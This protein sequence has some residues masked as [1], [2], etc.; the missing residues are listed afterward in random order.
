MKRRPLL[1]IMFAILL[2]SSCGGGNNPTSSDKPIYPEIKVNDMTLNHY[3]EL[4]GYVVE[5]YFGNS[6]SITIPDYVTVEGKNIPIV[7]ISSYGLQARQGKA[8]LKEVEL[9]KNIYS[10]GKFA[11]QGTELT[12]LYATPYLSKIDKDAFT[13]CPYQG[14]EENGLYFIPSKTAQ[15]CVMYKGEYNGWNYTFPTDCYS[16]LVPALVGLNFGEV[17]DLSN[18]VSVG[19]GVFENI[20]AESVLFGPNLNRIESKAFINSSISQVLFGSDQP[21]KC[22]YVGDEA[23]ANVQGLQYI[24]LPASIQELGNNVFRFS[25]DMKYISLPFVGKNENTPT[26]AKDFFSI[27]GPYTIEHLVIDRGEI[28]DSSF[29]SVWGDYTRTIDNLTLNHVTKVGDQAFRDALIGETLELGDSLVHA[30]NNA[31]DNLTASTVSIPSTIKYLGSS[32]FY[33]NS[34]NHVFNVGRNQGDSGW[35]YIDP[36]W[37]NKNN[38]VINWGKGGGTSQ[39]EQSIDGLEYYTNESG[40]IVTGYKGNATSLTVPAEINGVAF[41]GINKGAFDQNGSSIK[42]LSIPCGN[43]QEHALAGCSSLQELEITTNSYNRYIS[44]CWSWFESSAK[45][46]YY[47]NSGT[48]HI[49]NGFPIT[50]EGYI[51]S[52]LESIK[53]NVKEYLDNGSTSSYVSIGTACFSGMTS[54]KKLEINGKVEFGENAF[55][56]CTSL[57][58]EI[59]LHHGSHAGYNAIPTCSL[60]F[61][62]E[63]SADYASFTSGDYYRIPPQLIASSNV[64]ATKYKDNSGLCYRD[65]LR[66]DGVV[67]VGYE[68]NASSLTVP[69]TLNGKTVNRVAAYSFENSSIE[70]LDLTN[71]AKEMGIEVYA[72]SN[73]YKLKELKL[74]HYPSVYRHTGEEYIIKDDYSQKLGVLHVALNCQDQSS[75]K[76]YKVVDYNFYIPKSLKYVRIANG[77][78]PMEGFR[79]YVSL[80][81]VFLASDCSNIK[82]KAFQG[83]TGLLDMWIPSSVTNFGDYCFPDSYKFIVYKEATDKNLGYGNNTVKENMKT[84]YSYSQYCQEVGIQE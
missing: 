79:S 5:D 29:Q 53:L 21:S 42:K 67:I 10:I 18:L 13:D 69:A 46:G 41:S 82:A 47:K 54:L 74:H 32:S 12:T 61:Y 55:E 72:L 39:D 75:S 30:G 26:N 50:I 7:A 43:I 14:Y 83:C 27:S 63:N 36:S 4:G 40:Y 20:Q 80:E 31:F 17:L 8:K 66:V 58:G 15:H 19:E 73:M 68:G 76:S 33:A 71:I 81:R 6:T 3:D 34:G 45:S 1:T 70:T 16:V 38:T 78:I 62:L 22:T 44:N 35:E 56:A 37:Y 49:I 48:S 24:D 65:D 2:L 64:G 77:D 11:F 52:S 84:G 57:S 59:Y 9:G 51:P 25:G 60:R 23:F 28:A